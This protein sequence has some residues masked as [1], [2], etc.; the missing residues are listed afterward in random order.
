MLFAEVLESWGYNYRLAQNGAEGI[1]KMEKYPSA[2]I[3]TDLNMPV[4][5]GLEVLRRVKKKWPE[6][7]VVVITGY[8]TMENAVQ[9]MKQGAADF[10]SKPVNFEQLRVVINRCNSLIMN[11]RET[12]KLRDANAEL[13]VLNRLKDRFINITNHELRTP[14]TIIKG[15]LDILEFPDEVPRET[16]EG[17][18]TIKKTVDDMTGLLSQMHK[19]SMLD[20]LNTL[21]HIT[22]FPVKDFL[23]ELRT[24]F[25]PLFTRRK[26]NLHVTNTSN[27]K[28]IRGN[29]ILLKTAFRELLQNALKYTPEEKS[30][31]LDIP[32]LDENN[33]LISVKDEGI[34]IPPEEQPRIFD[35][36]YEVKDTIYH[37]SS[38]SEYLGGGLGIG[39]SIVKEIVELH[40]GSVYLESEVGKGSTFTLLLP[41]KDLDYKNFTV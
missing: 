37:F 31:Y 41:Q 23:E 14:L 12:E 26:V 3:L 35:R 8:G 1:Q 20:N 6:T 17:L 2:I 21:S 36:F 33:I 24:E 13:T 16:V 27:A 5:N 4:M 39:L 22:V 15:Y 40:D 34:G 28:A 9:A 29:K 11:R 32:S 19:L 18:E 25:L 7:E 38:D 30:V 10:I